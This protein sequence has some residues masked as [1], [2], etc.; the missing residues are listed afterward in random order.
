[1]DASLRR[2]LSLLGPHRATLALAV[3]ASLVVAAATSAYAFLLGPLLKVL[4]TGVSALSGL[5]LLSGIAA[6]RVL[7]VLPAAL[8]AAAVVRALAQ[9]AQSYLT[10][11]TGQRVVA[12]V[13]RDLYA[14]YL[15]LPQSLLGERASGDLLARFSADVQGVEM[16]LTVAVATLVRDV[17]QVLALLG[18]CAFLDGRLF[19]AAVAIVP[20]AAW[21]LSR[22]TR[23]LKAVMGRSQDA[24]GGF[25][26]RVGEAIANVR[27]VQAFAREDA[28]LARFAGEQDAYLR[29][30]RGSFL[31]RAAYSPVVELLGVCGVAAAIAFAGSA[32][33]RGTLT[34]EALLSFLTA[35]ALLY[36]P[37][38][39][40]A[41]TQQ[42]LLQGLAGARRVFE[43]LD[44][45]AR[46]E[47]PAQAAPATFER[48]VA[49]R[50]VGF[51]YDGKVPALAGI[52]LALPR[53]KTLAVVGESGSGKSTLVALLLRFWDPTSGRVEIDGR[54]ARTLKLADLRALFAY[55]PQEPVLFAGTVRDNLACAAPD[56][57]EEK[58]VEA[59][60]AAHAWEFV[61]RMAGGLDAPLGERGAGLSGGER[62]RLCLARALLTGAPVILLDE[63]TSALD[64]ASEALVQQGVEALLDHRT[65]LVIAHRLTTVQKADAIA[66]L[67]AGRLVEQGTHASLLAAGGA[68][69]ALWSAQAGGTARPEPADGRRSASC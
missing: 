34:G 42:H 39:S 54:D 43:L 40:L 17:L 53:G 29:L 41:A 46:I 62:Q 55:V 8:V 58:L 4:L 25:T 9:A 28:E 64:S 5:P 35:L 11:V 16:A 7:V 45:P 38:K 33:S 65:A 26:G 69:A 57:G 51:S 67:Q 48:E 10:A 1:M 37:L 56:A 19:L 30:Q 31:L 22:Y 60:K 14:R 47:E 15:A 23:A 3:L 49:L 66:V 6:D 61:Q 27:V 2:L 59:L 20:V 21:P 44:S 68:Y 12:R 32:I 36:Q 24:L 63:A 52:D 50:G 13:R 18:V